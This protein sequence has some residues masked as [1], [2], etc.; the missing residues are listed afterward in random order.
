MKKFGK[1]LFGSLLLLG[2]LS[3]QPLQPFPL[4]AVT[5]N[6]SP[7]YQ[8]EQTDL[9]YIL[10]LEPDRL[11]APFLR[12]A[13]LSPKAAPYG[14]WE[15]SG[16]D[17]HIGGHY[18]TALAQ[19]YAAT[20]NEEIH[21]RLTYMIDQ[22]ELCQQ[23]DADGYVG[24]IP[25][26]RAMWQEIA[27]GKIRA[28]S[29]SLNDKWVPLYNIHKLFAGLRDAYQIGGN[30]KALV[31]LTRLSGWF[32]QMTAGLSEDQIQDMLRSEH[33]GLNEVF[34]DV[35]GLTGDRRFL[36]LAEKFSHRAILDPLL[37]HQDKLTGQHANTQIPKVI[38]YQRIADLEELPAW[39]E[40]AAFFWETVV[41]HRSI[42]I[43]G[44][45]VR[46]H[47]NPIDDFS[48]MIET[49]QGPE[50]CNSY[51]MLRLTRLLFLSDPQAKYM[52][53][54]ERVLYNHI[55]SSQHPNGG[56]VY[57]T[58]IR[59]RHYRVYSQPDEGFWCCVGS[60]LENHGKYG[61]LIYTHQDQDLYVN[62]FIPSR[63]QW[64]EQ[65][66]ELQQATQFPF[67]TRTSLR[68]QLE[69]TKKF[70]LH[71]RYPSWV[72]AGA[73]EVTINGK[74]QKISAT[75]GN[76]LTL[77]RKWRSG[78]EVVLQLPMHTTVE[79]LPDGSN[80]ASF[81]HGPVVLA[82]ATEAT[83]LQGL[84]ADDSR[85]GHVADG[86]FY[87]IDTAPLLVQQQE[88]LLTGIHPVSGEPLTF[89]ASELIYPEQYQH[90]KLR[91][92]FQLHDARYML[93]WQVTTPEKL[94]ELQ[95]GLREKEQ[96]ALA[97]QGRTI[98]EVAAGE[99]QPESEHGFKEEK[100][101]AGNTNGRSWRMSTGGWFSYE[102]T[103]QDGSG[104]HLY[105]AVAR[106]GR[107][108]SFEILLNG[109]V[110]RSVDLPASQEKGTAV[111]EYALP[112]DLL[113]NS[114]DRRITVK[115]LAAEGTS[116]GP[117]YEIR[118]LRAE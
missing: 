11:L 29:F 94:L 101:Q 65:G 93:Y 41:E 33:G 85:M 53:Y 56:F 38:G 118:L 8:A 27:A 68:L 89:T 34:A 90:I 19:M 6:D 100:S 113:E 40:A 80:W 104:Q 107:E 86:R 82:A 35:A 58:P 10:A 66:L 106:A 9:Q 39:S 77:E 30:E 48:S 83:D 81:R 52:D 60:G 17:G 5:L 88:D 1:A 117:V 67:E 102:L 63:L 110:F 96:A 16:L 64:A 76:Y 75:P 115:L 23:Q 43:G 111:L 3:A 92:F 71:I 44:N 36:R 73:L 14:N 62:L 20:G 116:T 22:L 61:E 55:L 112:P 21:R 12:E 95:R 57:F 49:N 28:A 78:D 25:G 79:Y 18:L 13:G 74:W 103:N 7:F 42:S 24:G 37:A 31:V 59:P 2:S 15:G 50:T 114:T 87:P 4:S 97:L 51:N 108:R 109:Q 47:F 54:Y 45:S 98:D 99:Q 72:K 46:E 32:Y 105:L 70:G 26:G 91:P 69:K 84:K